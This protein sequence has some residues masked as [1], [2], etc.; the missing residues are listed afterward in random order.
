MA[1][2]LAPKVFTESCSACAGV[3]SDMPP[4]ALITTYI[5]LAA[6]PLVLAAGFAERLPG[7]LRAVAIGLGLAGFAM[8][9][10][11]FMSSGRFETLSGKVGINRAMRFHQI[12]AR[13]L[14]VFLILHPLFLFLPDRIDGIPG[15][16]Q[17]LVRM[18]FSDLMLSGTIALFLLLYMVVS[19]IWRHYLPVKYE[20][21]R[22]THVTGAAIV[23]IA[24]AH[25]VFSVGNYSQETFL[26]TYWWAMIAVA[27]GA[28][29]Y[30]YLIKPWRLARRAYQVSG[31]REV[32]DRIWEVSLEPQQGKSDKGSVTKFSAG[33]FAW[34]NFRAGAIPLFDNPFSLSSAPAELPRIRL[35]IKDRGDT[36]GHIGELAV[37]S[38]VFLDAPHGNFTLEGRDGDALCLIAGGIGISPIISILRDLAHKSDKRPISVLVGARSPRQLVYADE[39]REL[40][41]NLDLN[42]HFCV[43]K[44]PP[45]WNGSAGEFDDAAIR[46]CLPM[47]PARCLC[48]VCGPTQMML[49]VER[50]LRA[51]GVPPKNI[52]YER[53]EYD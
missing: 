42:L 44:P 41:E 48:M 50:H 47:V 26:R 27:L 31:V 2:R 22:G 53:F 17:M 21:W 37:G 8:L 35:L 14:L 33:Q 36:S 49:A 1:A 34:V 51:L 6:L 28:L 45:G 10:L 25:H 46:R 23:A 20:L 18:L 29:S 24:G 39:L 12:T 32:G 11:Q 9:L 15:A 3:L 30:R 52:V 13:L 7:S 4:A 5:A 40:K 43:D 16:V 38:T 19:S